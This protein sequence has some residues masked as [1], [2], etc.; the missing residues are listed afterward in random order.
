MAENVY[1]F[2]PNLIGYARI[3]LA[4]ASFYYMPTSPYV[5]G[6]LYLMSGFLDALDGHAARALNQ[7]SKYGA[8]LDMLTDRCATLC[9]LMT[10]SLF[11]PPWTIV[12]Q[13][14]VSL[15]ITSHWAQMYSSMMKG[16]LSHKSVEETANPFLKLYYT[17][18]VVLFIM[19]AGNELF[20]AMLYMIHFEPGPTINIFS[21]RLGLWQ[22]L[23]GICFPISFIK[24]LINLVQMIGAFQAIANSDVLERQKKK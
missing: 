18:R 13:F 6:F 11:Y 9:L 14:L 10:L 3:I 4:F 17:S 19:C 16:K 23:A 22:L 2:V 7:A 24:N 20:F 8:V 5:A 15:D 12:F 21:T 1:L